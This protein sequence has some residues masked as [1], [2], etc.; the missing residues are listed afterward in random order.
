MDWKKIVDEREKYQAYLCSRE[1]SK[2]REAVRKR[3]GD[4]CER[5]GINKIDAVHHLTYARKYEE[6]IEDLQGICNGCHEFIHGKSD[7]DP[8]TGQ[9]RPFV[10]VV[11][12][13]RYS[14]ERVA[15][16]TCP[17]CQ[18]N[19]LSAGDVEQPHTVNDII[20]VACSCN[21]CSESFFLVV[22]RGAH[23]GVAVNLMCRDE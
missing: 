3:C 1:W 4:K 7:V 22:W 20:G 14:D 15:Q 18:S 12:R 19:D 10:A 5:C 11:P 16:V 21:K 9:A 17:K 2:K 23:Y 6:R 8:K 13:F